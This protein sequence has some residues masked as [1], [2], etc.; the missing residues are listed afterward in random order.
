MDCE[1][2]YKCYADRQT[3]TD[4]QDQQSGYFTE[5]DKEAIHLIT[6][7]NIDVK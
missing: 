5:R 6:D 4:T 3:D 1:L 2:E 7:L